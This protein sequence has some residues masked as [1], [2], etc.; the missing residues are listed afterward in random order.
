MAD[1]MESTAEK[2]ASGR[3]DRW[4]WLRVAIG[5]AVAPVLLTVLAG[6]IAF[7]I[8]GFTEATRIGVFA[9][10]ENAVEVFGVYAASLTPA[11]LIPGVVLIGLLRQRGLFVWLGV[12]VV[13]C[14][15]AS[16][17]LAAL[18]GAPVP[19]AAGLGAVF[20]LLSFAI[21]RFIARP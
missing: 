14:S 16:A 4:P 3:A 13:A 12:G 19:T 7:I 15:V 21:I 20:G 5:M 8:G 17:A 1:R 11:A 10:A 18:G 6:G 2:T 9:V